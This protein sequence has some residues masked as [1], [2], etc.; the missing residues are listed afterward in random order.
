MG[1]GVQ[2]RKSN[3]LTSYENDTIYSCVLLVGLV[4][5]EMKNEEDKLPVKVLATFLGC[6]F[7]CCTAYVRTHRMVLS[8]FVVARSMKEK[9]HCLVA[10]L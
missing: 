4:F 10:L 9:W 7:C 5:Y 3:Y 2:G 6:E 8:Q 1:K